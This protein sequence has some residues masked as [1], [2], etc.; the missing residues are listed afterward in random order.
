MFS[1][2]YEDIKHQQ[3][4]F[5]KKKISEEDSILSSRTDANKLSDRIISEASAYQKVIK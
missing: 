3:D 5:T 2:L 4:L 1:Y